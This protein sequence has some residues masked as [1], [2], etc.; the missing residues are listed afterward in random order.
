M[1]CIFTSPLLQRIRSVAVTELYEIIEPTRGFTPG[2]PMA[3]FQSL[4]RH[5]FIWVFS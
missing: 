2:Y 5:S 3:D 1:E 4:R